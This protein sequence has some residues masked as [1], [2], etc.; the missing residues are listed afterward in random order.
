MNKYVTSALALA[1][2]GSVT[3]ADPSD[4][5]WLELDSEINSLATTLTSPQDGM[6]WT[7]LLRFTYSYSS[8]DIATGGG[9]DISGFKFEDLDIAFFGSVAE[10][11]WRVSGDVDSSTFTLEDAYVYWDCGEFFTATAGRFKPRVL[12]SGFIDPEDQLFIDRTALGSSFD[13]WNEGIAADGFYEQ[14]T[15]WVAIHNGFNGQVSDHLFLARG[16]YNFGAGAAD[17]EGAM[18]GNDDLNGVV[19][20]FFANDETVFEPDGTLIGADVNGNFGQIGFGAEIVSLD[21]NVLLQTAQ[22]FSRI[23]GLGFDGDSTPYN[24]TVSYLVNPDWEVGLRYEDLDNTPDDTIISIVANWYQ[25]G[26][27]AKWQFQWSNFDSDSTFDGSVFQIG[28]VVGAT[29]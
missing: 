23:V 18:G 14:F 11:G 28:V 13:F 27:N 10:Y 3:Y 15:W 12:R 9:D 29:R 4:S 2:A 26:N 19:G 7:A 17:S 5:D 20:V 25:S 22:D 24:L 6:G 16:E 8:D 1:I 21:D